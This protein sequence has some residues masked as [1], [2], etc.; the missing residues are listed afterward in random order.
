MKNFVQDGETVTLTAPYAVSSGGGALIGQLFGVAVSD[1][2]NGV[3][4][5][6]CLEGVF[7]LTA[8]TANTFAEGALVYWDNAAK[9]CTSTSA[10]NS[11]I[12]AAVKAKING[13][14]TVRVRLN[15]VSVT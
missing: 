6:F 8:V 13:D 10:G 7:D 2:A 5:E 11:K 14:T 15:E 4:G 9:N 12:G 3:Q 1:V